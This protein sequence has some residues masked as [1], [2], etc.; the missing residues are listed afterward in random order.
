[1]K[2]VLVLLE[3]LLVVLMVVEIGL[4]L[5]FGLGSPVLYLGDSDIGYLLAPNQKTRRYGNQIEINQY[6]MRSASITPLPISGTRR[7]MLLGDSLVNGGWWTDQSQTLSALIGQQLGRQGQG[8]VLNVSANSWGPPNQLAYLQRFGLFGSEVIVLLINTDDLF[9]GPPNPGV[10]GR[11]RNY[12]NTSPRLALVEVFNRR[13]KPSEPIPTAQQPQPSDPVGYNLEK[14]Q[15]IEAIARQNNANF[16]LAM[17]PLLREVGEPGSRDYEIK[18]RQRLTEFT[19][20]QNWIYID[21]LPIFKAT[22]QPETLYRDHIHLSPSGNQLVS[23]KI[24]QRLEEELRVKNKN[25]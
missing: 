6:S 14:I 23:E 13:L 10:V 9:T 4:R 17:T 3:I 21:F 15:G 19:Q 7:V 2:I 12:P 22:S 8:E 24:S 16:I 20:A 25:K 18:A 11:D 1:M 5:R